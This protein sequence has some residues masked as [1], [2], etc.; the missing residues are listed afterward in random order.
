MLS[1]LTLSVQVLNE[2]T[3]VVQVL[4]TLVVGG[5]L[6]MN[7]GGIDPQGRLWIGETDLSAMVR[8]MEGGDLENEHR[9]GRLWCFNGKTGK[10]DIMEHG[11]QCVN[12]IG[13]SP[14]GKTSELRY[15]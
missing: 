7:D 9:K 10:C 2:K 1:Q 13:W 12:G 6:R 5:E 8:V 14:D 4:R 15:S 3:G 11:F